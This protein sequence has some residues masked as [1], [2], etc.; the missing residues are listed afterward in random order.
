MAPACIRGPWAKVSG[1]MS[2]PP[3][4]P[5]API[6]VFF[7]GA[8]P[9]CAREIAFYRDRPGAE[10]LC[11]VD[12][13]QA[14]PGALAPGLTREAALA[15]LHVRRADGSLVSGA[16]AFAEIWRRVPGFRW[17]GRL[18]GVP[19]LG[20]VAEWGYRGFLRVRRAWR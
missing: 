3:A 13:A 8:C 10:G 4:A 2:T 1:S 15:R 14:G 16:A 5:P 9:V 12:A 20:L 11:W 6:E 18:L 17:L 19:P 7:D